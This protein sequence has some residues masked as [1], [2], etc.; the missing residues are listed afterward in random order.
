MADN[1]IY[2][3]KAVG[4]KENREKLLEIMKNDY[5]N[6]EKDPIRMWRLFSAEEDTPN[7]DENSIIIVGDCA[8]SIA[9]CMFKGVCS[10]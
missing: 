9:T 5:E 3:L 10:C 7:K 1:C 8:W 6:T 2:A 4:T